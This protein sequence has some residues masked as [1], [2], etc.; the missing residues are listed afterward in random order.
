[1]GDHIKNI[2][3]VFL[4]FFIFQGLVSICYTSFLTYTW[5]RFADYSS[6]INRIF[7][8]GI[9]NGILVSSINPSVMRMH[10]SRKYVKCV[11]ID[12]SYVIPTR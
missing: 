11:K 6:E 12:F 10:G 4:F 5:V 9:A 2:S 8:F 1:M 3:V 7:T